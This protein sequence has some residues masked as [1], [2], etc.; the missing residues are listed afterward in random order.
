MR[1]RRQLEGGHLVLPDLPHYRVIDHNAMRRTQG[2]GTPARDV[3]FRPDPSVPLLSGAAVKLLDAAS[4]RKLKVKATA[5]PSK[6]S[7]VTKTMTL[8]G[9]PKKK[10][11]KK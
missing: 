8:T 9:P 5:K 6:G 4:H 1:T 10:T 2:P 3:S 7:T 11:R